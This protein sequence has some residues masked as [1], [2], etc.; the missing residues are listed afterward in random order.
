MAKKKK[1]TIQ[2]LQQMKERGERITMLTA[3]D[4]TFGRLVDKAGVEMILV[5]D[6]LGMVIQGHDST[7]PV[8]VDH[9]IYHTAAV[10]RG[11]KRAFL[12]ADMPFGSYQT[13]VEDAVRNATRLLKEGGAEAVKL[14]GGERVVESVRRLTSSG[15]PVMGHLGLTPQ[16]VHQFGGHLVQG[17]DD[18]AAERIY[19]DALL[20]QDAGCFSIVLEGMPWRVAKRVS[21]ALAIPTIGIGAGASCDGQV[22]VIYDLLGMDE[23]F[24][25][26]FLKK[27]DDLAQ[28][29]GAAVTRYLDE[30]REGCFPGDEHAFE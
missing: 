3:Y 15:I 13:G 11:A 26:K 16:S 30:V 21:E 19:Q 10:R 18:A 24:N 5:G 20:L 4:A 2:C 17:R 22:L 23:R 28:G 6:S 8:E 9:V 27:Y 29:V 25:P 1:V 7:I 12:V 14:E